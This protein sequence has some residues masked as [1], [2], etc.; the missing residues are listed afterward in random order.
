VTVGWPTSWSL[1][2][3]TTLNLCNEFRLL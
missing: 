1:F 3:L 2:C